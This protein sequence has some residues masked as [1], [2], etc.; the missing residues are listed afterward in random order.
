MTKL[1]GSCR[2]GV[3]LFFIAI[4][5]FL[6][7]A[8]GQLKVTT[9]AGG[10][11]ENGV[12]AT[13]AALTLPH[14]AAYDKNGNLYITE[15]FAH[16]I[17]KVSKSGIITTIAGNGISGYSGDGGPAKSAMIS[18]P[19]GL[20]IDSSGSIYFSDNGNQRVRKI[21]AH[22]TITTV[23]G[24]G[25]GGFSGDGGPATDAELWGPWG[26]SFDA[27]GNLYIAEELNERVRV[28]NTSGT[29]DT[30][31]GNGKTGFSGDGGKATRAKLNFPYG[32][33]ADSSGNLYIADLNN[34]RVRVVNAK[35]KINTFAGN[36]NAACNGDGGSATAA[37]IGEPTGLA[38][39]GGS[40]LIATEI[41]ST[42]RTVNLSSNIINTIAGTHY[43]YDGDGHA[44]LSSEFAGPSDVLF[45]PVGDVV[46]VDRGNDRVREVDSQSQ[47]VS[48]IAGGYTGDGGKGTAS[49]LNL[50]EGMGF[51]SKND[52]YIADTV[53]HRA[54]KLSATGVITTLAGTGINGYGGDGGPASS[55][56]LN[57]PY[58]VTADP[59]GN[60]FI[61]D[62][63]GFVLREVSTNGV[64]NTLSAGLCEGGTAP[65]CQLLGL[66]ADSSGNVYGAD[67]FFCAIWEIT[68]SGAVTTVAGNLNQGCGYNGD[69][70]PATQALLNSPSS[71]TLDA[72]GDIYICD[73]YNNRVRRVD[74]VTGLISTVAGNGVA[75]FS[76]D[77]GPATSAMLNFP[78]GVGV[79]GKG[80][81]Y[82]ADTS[83]S[84]LRLVDG[85]GT[86]ETYAG[87]GSFAGYNGNGLP[88]NETNFDY[89]VGVSVNN[90]GIVYVLDTFQYRA[91]EIH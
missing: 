84:R 11:V 32:L 28:V 66:A 68:P 29:I 88:A 46:I 82:I 37:A 2:L 87:T 80:N 79:D 30:F 13:S 31:A 23:A 58:G 34:Y 22:G 75:G 76:G 52:L 7:Y 56:T 15:E 25:T 78:S 36:G 60:V 38:I 50:P 86:I 42:I 74:H 12:A 71:V 35:G 90:E 51:D 91:R 40:L 6:P 45:D 17:R 5:S 55:A 20:T 18:F 77:G 53:N 57:S 4:A 73:Q 65:F 59:S 3:A 8:H 72:A 10:G 19:T 63:D 9:V 14:F 47:I 85:S 81:L 54:R 27:S 33:L 64:I 48:S 89:L 83:N 61:A 67:P 70:I 39:G 26:L 41:C 44:A 16:R 24:N 43:G 1:T 49:N 62:Q 69:G 21:D